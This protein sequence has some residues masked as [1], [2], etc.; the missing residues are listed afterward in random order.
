MASSLQNTVL[1]EFGG[2]DFLNLNLTNNEDRAFN[3][4]TLRFYVTAKPEDIEAQPGQNNQPGTCPLLVDEDIC[5][6]YDEA[7]FN[8]P[9]VNQAGESVDD[10]LRYYLRHA[11]PV[12]LEDTYNPATGEYDK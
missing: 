2:M 1:Y 4:L 10:S 6:A 11:V 3:E 8:R 9:C 7:G 12:K 5:Q